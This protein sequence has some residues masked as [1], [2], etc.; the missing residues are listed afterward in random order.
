MDETT[1]IELE[2]LYAKN[3]L[4]KRLRAEFDVEGMDTFCTEHELPRKFTIDLMAQIS[5]HRRAPMSTLVGILHHHFG[6]TKQDLQTCADTIWRAAEAG[7]VNYDPIAWQFTVRFDVSDAVQ[8]ELERFQYPLP[9]VV[10]PRPIQGNRDT[11]YFT[12]TGSVIL[13]DNHHEDDVCLDH[14]NRVNQIP[15]VINPDTARMVVNQWRNLD[16]QKEGETQKDF[17]KRLRAFEKYD[18][19]SRDVIDALFMTGE[20]FYLTHRYDKRGRC[21]AQGYHV[22]TQGNA[23][24]KAMIEFAD[25]ELVLA[26]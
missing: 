22:T 10:P 14:L 26:T 16:H 21:Y 20:P 1:Q 12:I 19:V 7:V 5:L 24:N 4:M 3:H 2:G 18:R 11:G 6:D 23:W 25:Q 9:M 13:K 8:G 17:E 15:L